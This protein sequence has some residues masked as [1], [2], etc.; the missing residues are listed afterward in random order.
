MQRSGIF[1][2]QHGR[3]THACSERTRSRRSRWATTPPDLPG[4][5]SGLSCSQS[6]A[7]GSVL[8]LLYTLSAGNR[9]AHAAR[10]VYG[11]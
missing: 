4:G 5:A 10:D 6:A 11:M 2:T 9:V 3:S 8:L 7:T 1:E